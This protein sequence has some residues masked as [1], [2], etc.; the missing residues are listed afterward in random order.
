MSE[1]IELTSLLENKKARESKKVKS[2]NEE[3][4]IIHLTA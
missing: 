4:N 1:L 3:D 2:L